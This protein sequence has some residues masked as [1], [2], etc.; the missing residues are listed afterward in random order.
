MRALPPAWLAVSPRS[1]GRFRDVADVTRFRRYWD[2][3]AGGYERRSASL[4]QRYL[5]HGRSWVATRARGDV[6]EVAVGTGL[7]LPYYPPG[8]RLT[9]V[10]WSPKMLDQAHRR[11]D[12]LGLDARLELGDARE[13][14]FGDGTFDTVV[15]TYA[16]C[17][18]PEPERALA[19]AHRVLRPGGELLIAD[20]VVSTSAPA[21]LVQRA[22]EVILR[23]NGEHLTRRPSLLLP[24][25]GFEIVESERHGL[26]ILERVRAVRR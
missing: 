26:G 21:R 25:A 15:C 18:I 2:A 8:V 3:Q 14:P 20:H 22:L 16:L 6:L 11:V 10:E 1:R 13:L 19:E 9:A 12:E 23:G 24:D 5:R 7:T 17:C 4:E